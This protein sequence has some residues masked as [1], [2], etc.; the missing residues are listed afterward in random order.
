MI[1]NPRVVDEACVEAQYLEKIGQKKGKPS[2]SKKKENQEASKEGNE[3]WKGGKYKNTIAIAHQ[4]KDPSNRCNH[5]N[6][7]GH[8]K[9]KCC[10]LHPELNP[11]NHKKEAKKNNLLA[12]NPSNRVESSLDVDENMF[13][14]SIQKEVSLGSHHHQEEKDMTK[15]FH[16]KIQVK[17]TKIDALF[18][19]GS[20]DNCRF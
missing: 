2:G 15:F 1:F 16:I 17:K 19:L 18:D 8:T 6:I 3:K 10:K 20:Q 11:K 4:C 13:F 14:T 12:K 9:E 7:D 5:C